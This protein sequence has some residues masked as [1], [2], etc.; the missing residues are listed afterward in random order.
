MS[1]SV[2]L[3]KGETPYEYGGAAP[4]R[5]VGRRAL[6]AR[7]RVGSVFPRTCR[8]RSGVPTRIILIEDHPA[9]RKGLELLLR[10]K[11]CDVL[12]AGG[13]VGEARLLLEAHAP[14]V[15]VIDVHLGTE[16][17]I[18]LTRELLRDHPD[19][20][21]VLYTGSSD[22]ELLVEGLDAGAVG[23]AL[24]DG[25]PD[26]L[27]AAI[28]A[29]VAG[30]LYVDPRL[31]DA[32]PPVRASVERTPALS[33]REREVM[34][35]LSQ[36]LTGEQVAE[37]LFLSAETVK[38]HVRNAMGKLD[39]STRVHAIALAMRD[40]EIDGPIAGLAYAASAVRSPK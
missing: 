36:G 18:E 11:G 23:Y 7:F 37:L 22:P 4:C 1:F 9:L 20:R 27:L 28:A 17:G 12:G 14:E 35:H 26:E 40:G 21:V 2:S 29:A 38:T 16:S 5:G 8:Y 19:C 13:T 34:D 31:R 30:E 25:D 6:F 39:A 33:K 24:K 32:L 10:H 3:A 15:A